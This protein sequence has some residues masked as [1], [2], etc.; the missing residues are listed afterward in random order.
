MSCCANTGYDGYYSI[1][2]FMLRNVPSVKAIVLY[3]SWHNGPAEVAALSAE[4]GP[5]EDRLRNALGWLSPFIRPPTLGSRPAVLRALYAPTPELTQ[6][7]LESV[8]K[9]AAFAPVV[10]FLRKN[11]GWW[12]EHDL[13][14]NPAK[15]EAWL[16]ALCKVGMSKH[17]SENA[18]RPDI[19][20]KPQSIAQIELRRLANLV[21]RLGA[22]LIVVF[23]PFTARQSRKVTWRSGWLI[24]SLSPP[25]IQTS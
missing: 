8:D 14:A 16:D 3:T 9:S 19:F 12:P 13:R 15:Y 21:A 22:K 2:E 25:S 18:Y 17:D 4:V 1:A 5:G 11:A 24:F 23:Q 6:P 20:T 10:R 7:G